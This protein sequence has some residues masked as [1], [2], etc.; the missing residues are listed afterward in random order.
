MQEGDWEKEEDK[1]KA[2]TKLKEEYQGPR[3][4]VHQP[5][6]TRVLVYQDGLLSSNVTTPGLVRFAGLTNATR[7]E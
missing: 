7:R 5:P 1:E 6:Q 2:L 3:R 4:D